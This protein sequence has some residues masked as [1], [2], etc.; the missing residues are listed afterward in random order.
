MKKKYNNV[1]QF[2]ITLKDIAPP[3]FRV[4]QVPEIYTFWDL[5]VAIQDSMGWFD[6]HLHSFNMKNPKTK[7]KAEIG[8]P[9]EEFE[10]RDVL[11][12]WIQKISKW[13]TVEN[14]IADY[15]Y[16]FGDNWEHI[17]KLEKIVPREKGIKYPRCIYGERACPPEDCGSTPGYENILEII[18]DKNHEEYE[19]MMEWLGGEYDPEYFDIKEIEFDDP[20]K[21][22]KMAFEDTYQDFG[23][24]PEK[25]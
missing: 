8:I 12:E 25:I 5:H 1:Y 24:A 21:R 20:P 17:I 11:P 15:T 14:K 18:K 3:I 7:E 4:I 19:S 23:L 6:S 22:W 13:F 10:Y 16:D 9:D 2:K